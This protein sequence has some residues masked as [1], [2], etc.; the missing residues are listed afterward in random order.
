MYRTMI[1]AFVG[2]KGR[3]SIFYQIAQYTFFYKH[4]LY[5][6]RESQICPKIKGLVIFNGGWGGGAEEKV[7]GYENFRLQFVGVRKYFT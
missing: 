1:S 2:N 4:H 6:H 3:L 5:K 7:E